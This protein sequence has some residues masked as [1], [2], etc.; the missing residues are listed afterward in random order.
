MNKGEAKPKWNEDDKNY[1]TGTR[2][3]K[4]GTKISDPVKITINIESDIGFQPQV[5]DG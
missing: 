1:S 2:I 4:L 3:I 5:A